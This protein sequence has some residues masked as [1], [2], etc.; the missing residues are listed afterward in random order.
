MNAAESIV[1]SY[2]RICNNCLTISDV[3]VKN[4]NN[5][6]FDLLAYRIEGECQ[7]H[8]EVSV[9]HVPKWCPTIEDL[10]KQ[11]SKKFFGTSNE[12]RGG[13]KDLDYSVNKS[14]I[15]AIKDSYESIGFDFLAVRRVWVCW[16]I[17]GERSKIDPLIVKYSNPLVCDGKE[18]EIEIISLRDKIL[19]ELLK[20]I[21]TSNYENEIIRSLSLITQ[22]NRQLDV[23]SNKSN[24]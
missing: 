22:R 16:A 1:E 9:T 19:P 20:K 17:K 10:N 15:K 11:F 7:Y 3:K 4:G 14:Y 13:K 24:V 23:L 8:I 18:F 6:Q 21:S 2:Y 12:K 5:R